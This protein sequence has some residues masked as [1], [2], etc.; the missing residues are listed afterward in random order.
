V[1]ATI[2]ATR[3]AVGSEESSPARRL[4]VLGYR[5]RADRGDRPIVKGAA[6]LHSTAGSSRGMARGI[7]RSATV[8]KGRVGG[9]TNS[10]SGRRCCVALYV[11]S[12][13]LP[14]AAA[15]AYPVIHPGILV[16]AIFRAVS[17]RCCCTAP[18]HVDSSFAI[19]ACAFPAGCPAGGGVLG[20]CRRWEGGR[21]CQMCGAQCDKISRSRIFDLLSVG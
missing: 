17:R 1:D 13:T 7:G 11:N 4:E 10:S 5:G 18:L 3:S 20:R 19:Q 9:G 14:R 12:P 2:S 8:H 21:R 6:R 16:L 15:L